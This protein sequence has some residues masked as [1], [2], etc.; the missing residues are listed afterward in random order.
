[1]STISSFTEGV[2]VPSY[3]PTNYDNQLE[4]AL[5]MKKTNDYNSVIS[6]LNS[7]QN[8][9]LNISMMNLKGK[10]KLDQYNKELDEMLSGDIGDVLD[11]KVQ[12]K[13]A[14][15]FNRVSQDSDLK[16]RNR[17]SQHYQQ[18]VSIIEQMRNSKDPSKSGYNS[19]NEQVFKKW[20]GGLE[21]FMLADN[22]NGWESKMIGYTPYKDID[23]KLVNL[24]KLL[25][26]E[27]Q[28]TQKPVTQKIKVG[29]KEV[30]V[31][32]GY[33]VLESTNGV[34]S[35]R[36]RTL[37]ESTLDQDERSQLDILAKYRI[38][39]NS[40][41]EGM[42]NL[43]QSYNRWI[44]SENRNT[45]QQLERVKAAKLILDPS[46]ID[47]K[48]SPEQQAIKKAQY[49]L[50]LDKLN[51]QEE[52]LTTKLG[53][54]LTNQF[55]EE[56]WSKKSRNEL[57]P[58]VRQLTTEGYVNG[59]ADSL[60]WKDQIQKVGMDDTYFANARI[61]TMQDRLNLDAELGRAGLKLKELELTYKM[62]KDSQDSSGS[63]G[64]S[65]DWTKPGDIIKSE[66]PVFDTWDKLTGL[67]KEYSNKTTPII[68][69]K[70][71]DK[72]D[73]D[74][75]NL[76]NK[77]WLDSN[78]GNYE[79]QLWNAYVSRFRDDGAFL[80][81]NYSKPNLVGFE[82]FKKRVS[83]GYYKNDPLINNIYSNFLE[84]KDVSDWLTNKVAKVAQTV[85]NSVDY[86]SVKIGDHSLED[87]ARLTTG[88]NGQGEMT[89]NVRDGKGYKT[90]TW[91]EVKEEYNRSKNG[92]EIYNSI[93]GQKYFSG[94]SL[95]DNDLPFKQLVGKAIEKESES[96]K[97]IQD[98][99]LNELPQFLQ[100]KQQISNS[101][102]E[103]SNYIININE[104]TKLADDNLPL[105]LDAK[106]ITQISRPVGIGNSGYF[107]IS[108]QASKALEGRK[109]VTV[110]NQIVNDP[111]PN[112]WYKYSVPATNQYDVIQNAMFEDT[113]KVTRNIN[114][115]N[116]TISNNQGTDYVTMIIKG[117]DINVRQSMPRKDISLMF[118]AAKQAIDNVNKTNVRK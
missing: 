12:S 75:K 1:M 66:I 62:S 103:I 53:Q 3:L 102:K 94:K 92:S 37:L 7:L 8:T 6:R 42:S 58:Y 105:G 71:G 115:Y 70:T 96:I 9:S 56:E 104:A 73:I 85:N 82:V 4:M 74:P 83:N 61:K 65:N 111:K 40:T 52:Y 43:Y 46:K 29:D 112:V 109:L 86:K 27:Q 116:V 101:P 89:F 47:S 45:K 100:G 91:S 35:E 36:I 87:Y 18:Q 21:D 117:D 68:T 110:G 11:P 99:Y 97:M 107:M 25:H 44:S 69:S 30:E 50:E 63:L 57:F 23:Q 106:D 48:L 60:S 72:Y 32:T 20:D 118:E 54:Q 90:L 38:L 51:E 17:L 39:E 67:Q 33:D 28:T 49:Q 98:I 19:I 24:T 78:K 31:P 10:Q 108:E 95:L 13:I 2:V 22:V 93:T 34:S 14:G 5:V 81:E 84:D 114:G 16:K 80:D 88:W 26:A 55:S 77:T 59:V 113:G 41:P 64:S 76:T 79:V 15:Y